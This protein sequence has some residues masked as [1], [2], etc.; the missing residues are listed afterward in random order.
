MRCNAVCES[1]CHQ[2][3]ERLVQ[4]G[5]VVRRGQKIGTIG[6]NGGMYPVHLHFELRKTP[7]WTWSS[8]SM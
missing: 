6:S 1:S 3:Q 2:L 7:A 8:R 5:E 4:W